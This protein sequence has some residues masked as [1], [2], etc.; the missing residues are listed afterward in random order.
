MQAGT[1]RI[2]TDLGPLTGRAGQG[3][4]PGVQGTIYVRPEALV[5]GIGQ[6]PCR[7]R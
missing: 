5:P 4:A 1:A 2:E 3:A 7:R 6:N